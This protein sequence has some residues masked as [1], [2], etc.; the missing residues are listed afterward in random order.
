V[1]PGCADILVPVYEE[2][3]SRLNKYCYV[4][5]SV[6]DVF[7]NKKRLKEALLQHG[8]SVVKEY[9]YDEV[10]KRDFNDYPLFVKPV[11]NNSSKGM[12]IVY[13]SEQLE[14]AYQK[15]LRFSRSKTVLIE[16]YKECDDFFVGYFLQDGNV[17]VTFTGDRFVIRQSG[18][19]SITS[20]L[21]YPSKYEQLYFEAV[22]KKMCS[23]FENLNFRNGICA[24]QGFVENGE[25]MFYD[26][27][28]R[29][30]GGQEYVLIKHFTG[31]DELENLIH[32]ALFGEMCSGEEYKKCDASFGGKYG[33]NLTF[34]VEPCTIGSVEGLEYARKKTEVLNVTQ[35][36]DVGDVID[37]IGT[38]Q[39]NISRMH[40]VADSAQKLKNII[41]ELQSEIRVLDV[42]GNNVLIDGLDP[43]K[44]MEG[45][46]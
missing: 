20:G 32:F 21:I 10:I 35:E 30:T 1:L 5:R 43:K 36:H 8:L 28:L 27:A 3:C 31:L 40:I 25:I 44:W 41:L 18:V 11:D 39:Q 34:S 4:N 12:S 29:I 45:L 17:E 46:V 38:A 33:C 2:I 42:E 7:N 16:E 26:P 23:L 6:V 13:D 24:I 22:H 9:S 19:G 14:E 37:K 15:A